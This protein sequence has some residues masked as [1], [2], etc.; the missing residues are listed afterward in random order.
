MTPLEFVNHRR[1]RRALQILELQPTLTVT[2]LAERVGYTS[3]NYFARLFRRLV[4]VG[5]AQYRAQGM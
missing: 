1:V 2:E 3:P 5:L 4:G